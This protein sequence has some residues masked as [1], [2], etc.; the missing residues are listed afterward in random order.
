MHHNQIEHRFSQLV[1]LLDLGLLEASPREQ[2]RRIVR[3]CA[4]AVGA[5]FAEVC[6]DGE[7]CI[8][9]AQPY[10]PPIPEAAPLALSAGLPA[11]PAIITSQDARFANH[12]VARIL[13]LAAMMVWPVQVH[14]GS[15]TLAIAWSEP[16][17][18]D[19][20]EEEMTFM[21]FLATVVSRLLEAHENQLRLNERIDHD[22]L[23][24][25]H[26]R[27]A[28]LERLGEAVSAAQRAGG[29]VALLYVD[30][31]RFKLVND[32]YGHT[33]GDA[34]LA[35]AGR[36][37]TSVLR[38]HEVA[39]RI[40]GD[41]FA[42]VLAPLADP[43]E[44]DKL[45]N[46]L[47]RAL[48]A[49]MIVR[50]VT[51]NISA[52]MGVGVFPHDAKTAPELIA[53]A[54]DAMYAAKKSGVSMLRKNDREVEAPP[55]HA[56]VVDPQKFDSHYILCVQPIV[57]ARSRRT[58]GGEILARWLDPHAGLLQPHALLNGLRGKISTDLDRRTL[59]L[60]LRN[61]AAIAQ[62]F[63]RIQL[64]VNI[65]EAD[66]QIFEVSDVNHGIS[67]ELPEERVAHD[68]ERF[69][70]FIKACR[71]AGFRVGLSRFG[72]S[73]LTLRTLARLELDFVKINPQRLA[74]GGIDPSA[75]HALRTLVEHARS[76]A[77]VVIAESIESPRDAETFVNAGVDALQGYSI[78]SPL[79]ALD[80][81]QWLRYKGAGQC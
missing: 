45:A 24:G 75:P 48:T 30:L 61:S 59:Q 16:R 81:V 3:E 15:A 74:A 58:I 9:A 76:V 42:I 13:N 71:S 19:L 57:D 21:T 36:R 10:A 33:L 23:T 8:V 22:S 80:F 1:S 28:L 31:D 51:L 6:I 5:D 27:A 17:S 52:S 55:N 4:F 35:E 54:D 66:N 63:G 37:M 41:E 40:G 72:A 67:L 78:C 25:L 32:T 60:A 73:D 68:P 26:N 49:P 47:L 69:I 62:E 12:P 20:T 79:T 39:G 64:F 43:G 2:L 44:I 50:N 18:A 46:R 65:D 53:F 29:E 56:P 70:P 7:R 34:A 38:K 11:A 14:V 77:Q